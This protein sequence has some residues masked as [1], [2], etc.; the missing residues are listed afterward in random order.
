MPSA[1]GQ[2]AGFLTYEPFFAPLM[3]AHAPWAWGLTVIHGQFLTLIDFDTV[4]R[5]HSSTTPLLPTGAS[6]PRHRTGPRPPVRPG[7]TRA[8]LEWWVNQ[9]NGLLAVITDPVLFRDADGQYV[10]QRT[11]IW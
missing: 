4:L 1:N 3:L 10:P 9:L 6:E 8:G 2:L 11:S 5:G 7:E